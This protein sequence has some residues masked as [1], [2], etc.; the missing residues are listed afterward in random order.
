MTTCQN[1]YNVPTEDVTAK[2]VMPTGSDSNTGTKSDPWLTVDKAVDSV[3]DG[4][5]IYAKTNE[6]PGDAALEYIYDTLINKLTGIGYVTTKAPDAQFGIRL[7]NS[8]VTLFEGFYIEP[9]L[10]TSNGVYLNTSTSVNINKVY[11]NSTSSNGFAGEFVELKHTVITGSNIIGVSFSGN[12]INRIIDTCLITGSTSRGIDVATTGD[13]TIKNNFIKNTSGV[14]ILITSI[15]GSVIIKGN[16]FTPIVNTFLISA[17]SDIPLSIVYNTF[18]LSAASTENHISLTTF[19][20]NVPTVSNN[21]IYN[22]SGSIKSIIGG[23]NIPLISENNIINASTTSMAGGLDIGSAIGLNGVYS[24]VS[25]NNNRIISKR[26]QSY[27][28]LIGSENTKYRR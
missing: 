12:G 1:F 27:H 9:Q 28:V 15:S 25:I 22:E 4:S 24:E 2:W 14:A 6:Y 19:N 3:N 20:S 5:L 7:R 13:H 11:L 23:S 10:A 17:T 18:Y 26:S 8:G 16:I 21:I